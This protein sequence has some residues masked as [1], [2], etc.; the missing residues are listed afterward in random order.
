MVELS[1]Q[2]RARLHFD[3]REKISGSDSTVQ[4]TRLATPLSNIKPQNPSPRKDHSI[5]QI[6]GTKI[7]Q[8]LNSLVLRHALKAADRV[9][10]IDEALAVVVHSRQD[11]EGVVWEETLVVQHRRQQLRDSRDRGLLFVLVLVPLVESCYDRFDEDK[12]RKESIS[13]QP[14]RFSTVM[15]S[16]AREPSNKS[17]TDTST[18]RPY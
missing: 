5:V 11:I 4:Y 6:A 7:Y 14:Q 16:S 13:I 17:S 12:A 2:G 10:M 3:L 15:G 18:P 9:I 1:E 8:N